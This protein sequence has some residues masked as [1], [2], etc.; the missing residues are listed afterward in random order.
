M[1][2]NVTVVESEFGPTLPDM[3]RVYVPITVERHCMVAV[4]VA[5]RL[6]GVIELHVR[7][8][9]VLFARATGPV[10]P[11]KNVTVIVEVAAVPR[12]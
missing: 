10:K 6:A 7:L 9:I 1:K 4:P 8:V 5:E 3:V 2:L 12:G 11:L